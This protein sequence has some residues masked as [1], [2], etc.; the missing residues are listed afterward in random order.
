MVV[1]STRGCWRTEGNYLF[2][3]TKLTD[4]LTDTEPLSSPAPFTRGWHWHC[5]RGGRWKTF[6]GACVCVCVVCCNTLKVPQEKRV[7]TWKSNL[8]I[9]EYGAGSR[10]GVFGVFSLSLSHSSCVCVNVT[11][12]S[13][14][15]KCVCACSLYPN[16][17][18]CF[19]VHISVDLFCLCRFR[20]WIN[21]NK[22]FICCYICMY[23]M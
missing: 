6:V 13:I 12:L 23:I 3:N 15:L 10:L 2:T 7:F 14:P 5:Q 4:R 1:V 19:S 16:L 22:Y 8:N 21:K 11:L 18:D 9:Q 17:S 20:A